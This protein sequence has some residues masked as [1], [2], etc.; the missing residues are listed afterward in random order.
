MK[1]YQVKHSTSCG[2]F[3]IIIVILDPTIQLLIVNSVGIHVVGCSIHQF[4]LIQDNLP[5]NTSVAVQ[6]VKNKL[7][8]LLGMYFGT[9]SLEC[10]LTIGERFVSKDFR[11]LITKNSIMLNAT[12]TT[13]G[14]NKGIL[15]STFL[16]LFN[17]K[18]LRYSV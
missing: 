13:Q 8:F 7:D 6:V 15:S 5:L 9:M 12:Y 2:C 17:R 11:L 10:T 1:S 3:A 14:A 16:K 18:W 4:L